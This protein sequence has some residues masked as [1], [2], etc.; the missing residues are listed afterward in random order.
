MITPFLLSL[1][2]IANST[3]VEPFACFQTLHK[4]W[5]ETLSTA[6]RFMIQASADRSCITDHVRPSRPTRRRVR[7]AWGGGRVA[8]IDM[9]RTRVEKVSWRFSTVV[10]VGESLDEGR[11][12][13]RMEHQTPKMASS[14][15]LP[16]PLTHE[17]LPEESVYILDGTSMLFRAFYGR[18]ASG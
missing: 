1:A 11:G 13:S 16:P 9:Y 10:F 4:P 15:N 14:R 8:T 6:H 18:G 2:L 12:A 7:P 17:Q 5:I 3:L